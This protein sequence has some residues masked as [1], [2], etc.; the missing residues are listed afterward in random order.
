MLG[1]TG[2]GALA[3]RREVLDALPPVLTGGSMVETV[4]MEA[5]TFRDA[6]AAVRGRHAAGGQAVG[7]AAAVDY[8]SALGMDRVAAHEHALTERLLAGVA[9]RR[10]A[11]GCSGPTTARTGS[12]R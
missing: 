2:I 10:R 7:L 6:A 4:T 1:P 11:C 5:T 8:L 12:A 3:G 9:Q